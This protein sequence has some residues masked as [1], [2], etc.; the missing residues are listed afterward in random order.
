M[1]TSHINVTLTQ[2]FRS[3]N[4]SFQDYY[5]QLTNDICSFFEFTFQLWNTLRTSKFDKERELNAKERDIE[6]LFKEFE[7]ILNDASD[8]KNVS[9]LELLGVLSCILQK[10]QKLASEIQPTKVPRSISKTSITNWFIEYVENLT[11]VS[12]SLQTI[13]DV[14]EEPVVKCFI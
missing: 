6:R 5:I 9:P 13:Q 14:F 1:D 7:D 12:E 2:Y 10:M 8:I 3:H 11:S 4:P